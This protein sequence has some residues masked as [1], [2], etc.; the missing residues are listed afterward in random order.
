MMVR[1]VTFREACAFVDALHRHNKAPRG[2][3]FS[4]GLFDGGQ[5]VGVAMIGRPVARALDDGLTAEVNRTCTDG[6]RNANSMLYGAAARACKAMGYNLLVTYTQAD[7][8]GASLRAA[9]FERDAD[10]PARASWADASVKLRGIR[11]P[12]GSGGVPRVR[13]VRRL[14]QAVA[15]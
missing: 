6:T 10:L 3:K 7:E 15:A 11:C 2:H 8:S 4:I 14:A 1:P 13:W 12:E 5:M 9:G